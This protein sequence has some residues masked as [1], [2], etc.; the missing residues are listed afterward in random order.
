MKRDLIT[1][2][3]KRKITGRK[4]FVFYDQAKTLDSPVTLPHMKLGQL[5]V[6]YTVYYE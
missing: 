2:K 1:A 5:L 6:T 4:L 3:K